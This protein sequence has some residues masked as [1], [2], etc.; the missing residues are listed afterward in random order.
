MKYSFGIAFLFSMCCCELAF[1]QGTFRNDNI[2]K[3]IQKSGRS[4]INNRNIASVSIGVYKDG[5]TYTQHFGSVEKRKTILPDDETIYEIGSVSKTIVG[6]LMAEA[7]LDGK[8]KLED[9]IRL[10]LQ[11]QY[12]NLE[13]KGKPITIKH[14]LT[15]T[16]GMPMFLPLEMNGVFEKLDESVPGLYL[17]M[18]KAYDKKKFLEELKEVSIS[19]NPGTDYAYSNAGG[20]LIGHILETLYQQS[21]DA[22]LKERLSAKYDLNNTGIKLDS[23]QKQKIALGYWMDSDSQS[24][25][26]F[27]SLWGTAGGIKMTIVDMMLY[28]KLQLDKNNPVV[29]ESHRLLYEEGN[30][31][32][33]SYFWR[34]WNDKYG[35]SYNHHGGTSGTQNWLFI[36]PKYDLGISII[37][38]QSGPKTPKLLSKTVKKMLKQL[39]KG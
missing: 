10:H 30:T 25:S 18:E 8:L 32:K 13:Y 36:F 4:F 17:E 27:N 14:L 21:I 39:T 7:V 2:S 15:H 33:L 37:T 23:V 12:P 29:S 3:T 22:L 9:D 20:E 28:A 6:Y 1:S 24:P 34:V 5:N 26:Q 16:S 19:T 38:N 31:F 11:G 35:T